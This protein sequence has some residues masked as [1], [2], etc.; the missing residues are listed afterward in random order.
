MALSF[1]NIFPN[2]RQNQELIADDNFRDHEKI[3]DIFNAMAHD[4]TLLKLKLPGSENDFSSCILAVDQKAFCFTLDEIYPEE[5]HLLISRNGYATVSGTIQGASIEF[6]ASLVGSSKT[7]Q[8]VNYTCS[9]PDTISY[10]QRRDEYRIKIPKT[11]LVRVTVQHVPTRQILQGVIHN[12]SRHGIGILLKLNHTIKPGEQLI[13]CKL[14]I[15]DTEVINFSLEVR[16]IQ[17]D[18]PQKILVG[19]E[20]R[21]LDTRA[22]EILNR[23]ICEMERLALRKK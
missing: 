22:E 23:F 4:R 12:I 14:A 6:K 10:N 15:D 13:H 9:I 16:H 7:G 19:G 1:K 17:S 8:F 5:G 21:G 20:F 18:A 3:I 2:F 11:H